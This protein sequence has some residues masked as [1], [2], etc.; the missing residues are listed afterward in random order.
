MKKNS[1]L[2][3]VDDVPQNIQVLGAILKNQG[4]SF[5]L[6]TSGKETYEL[7]EK[8][9]PD[10]IL[11]DVMLPDSD[12]FSIC[13]NLKK[14]EATA[15]IPVLFLTAKNDTHDKVKGFQVGAVD[16]IT[17]PFEE[18][19]VIERVKNHLQAKLDRDQIKKH[20]KELEGIVEQRTN[21]LLKKE[22]E[23]ILAQFIQ[24]VVHNIRGPISSALAALDLIQ[25]MRDELN[26]KIDAGISKVELKV[27][28]ADVWEIL[29]LNNE[30]LRKMAGNLESM[31]RKSRTDQIQEHDVYD[32]NELINQELEFLDVDLKFKNQVTKTI[33]LS[34]HKLP[35][36]V[37]QGDI[38]QVFENL[39]KNAMDAMHKTS[40]P[41]I[42]IESGSANE[43]HW[44][45]IQDSGSGIPADI[46][47]KIFDPF[48][49]TKPLKSDPTQLNPEPIGTGIGLQFC[50]RTIVA[51]NG[52]I[53]VESE[54]NQGAKF[55]IFLP[56]YH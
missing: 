42:I 17:K 50:K 31:L 41:K 22:R 51:N 40:N 21:E 14:T 53:E 7:L 24:G 30:V 54:P 8:V 2:L 13:E 9:T 27:Q 47:N 10:I 19:E 33:N 38:A 45:S 48:F 28:L 32:L 46:I 26:R 11:L 20:N 18:L 15:D 25:A 44:F 16:Y 55:T 56:A 34:N 49:T 52:K 1:L 5:A 6:T 29:E 23:T 3:L 35:V 36:F 37:S 43:F 12:G 4:Y 39:I